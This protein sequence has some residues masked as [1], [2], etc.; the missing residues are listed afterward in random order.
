[1][2]KWEEKR[3]TKPRRTE[4]TRQTRQIGSDSGAWLTNQSG[5]EAGAWNLDGT[6]PR[7]DSTNRNAERKG[8][9]QGIR[10]RRKPTETYASLSYTASIPAKS[11]VIRPFTSIHRLCGE[12]AYSGVTDL[13]CQLRGGISKVLLPSWQG[14]AQTGGLPDGFCEQVKGPVDRVQS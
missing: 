1:M 5:R 11:S 3:T 8:S 10:K 7:T 12:R 2:T 9:A 6:H 14:S 4:I 13:L